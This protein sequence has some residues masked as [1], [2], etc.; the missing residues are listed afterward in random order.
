[1][2]IGGGGNNRQSRELSRYDKLRCAYE[3]QGDKCH[4]LGTISSSNGEGARFYC[5]W[6]YDVLAGEENNLVNFSRWFEERKEGRGLH[7]Q[8]RGDYDTVRVKVRL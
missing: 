6:H 7:P 2:A 8:F 5:T 3:H 1:M 4:M